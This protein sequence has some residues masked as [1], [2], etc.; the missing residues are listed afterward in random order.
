MRKKNVALGFSRHKKT[1]VDIP[2]H[3]FLPSVDGEGQDLV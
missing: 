2:E 1:W 3:L